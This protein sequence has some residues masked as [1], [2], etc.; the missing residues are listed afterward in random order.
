MHDE[1]PRSFST[2]FEVPHDIL[3]PLGLLAVASG[4]IEMM[5]HITFRAFLRDVHSQTTATLVSPIFSHMTRTITDL[6]KNDAVA[7]SDPQLKSDWSAWLGDAKVIVQERNSLLHGVWPDEGC[8]GIFTLMNVHGPRQIRRVTPH[9]VR[10]IAD[11]GMAIAARA[12]F[13]GRIAAVL[14]TSEYVAGV[15]SSGDSDLPGGLIQY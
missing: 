10:R 4:R 8:D 3:E 15:P 13:P 5:A 7:A 6:M 1:S 14:R 9:E 12:D 2:W 11:R